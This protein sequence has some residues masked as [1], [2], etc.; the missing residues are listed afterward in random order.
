MGR[1]RP[2]VRTLGL[3]TS[4]GAVRVVSDRFKTVNVEADLST[5]DE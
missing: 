3:G 2:P 4:K 1:A 5:L